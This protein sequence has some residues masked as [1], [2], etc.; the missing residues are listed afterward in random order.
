MTGS[1]PVT[2]RKWTHRSYVTQPPASKSLYKTIT[3]ISTGWATYERDAAVTGS[4]PVT[5]RKRK[6]THRQRDPASAEQE[7][8]RCSTPAFIRWSPTVVDWD[9]R[10]AG[11]HHDSK[12]HVATFGSANLASS[13][14]QVQTSEDGRMHLQLEQQWTRWR[15]RCSSVNWATRPHVGTYYWTILK[16]YIKL[17]PSLFHFKIVCKYFQ[18]ILI[19]RYVCL[20]YKLYTCTLHICTN[21]RAYIVGRVGYWYNNYE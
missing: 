7:A 6:W 9:C 16:N 15:H 8:D 13:H 20:V 5:A 21:A 19:K 14:F 17:N 1:S 12:L 2:A 3:K 11:S 18:W 4:S 10:T